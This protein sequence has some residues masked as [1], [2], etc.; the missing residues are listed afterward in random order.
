VIRT[1][2]E[3]PSIFIRDKRVFLSEGMLHKD[4]YHKG[5]VEKKFLVVILKGLDAKAN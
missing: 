5:S 2:V 3:R 1:L 4:Y